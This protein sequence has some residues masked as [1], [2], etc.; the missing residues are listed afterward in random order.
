MISSR[1][2]GV[3]HNDTQVPVSHRALWQRIDRQL[4]ATSTRRLRRARGIGRHTLGDLYMVD[5][6]HN[7]VVARNVDLEALGRE[8]G[9]LQAFEGLAMGLA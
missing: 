8:M 7:G 1:H 3:M 9:V 5:L 6:E 4:R 2:C